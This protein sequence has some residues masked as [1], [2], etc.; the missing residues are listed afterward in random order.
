MSNSRIY[1]NAIHK[2]YLQGCNDGLK[3]QI[4]K[5][6]KIRH[7]PTS[8]TMSVEDCINTLNEEWDFAQQPSYVKVA[9]EQGVAALKKEIPKVPLGD[10]HSCPHYRCP[11]CNSG[12]VMYC[13]DPHYPRCQWCGQLLKWRK[14]NG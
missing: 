2:A 14:C 10:L 4:E 11:T 5:D 7:T 3:K 9:I 6:L 1:T 8:D 12:I 13:D